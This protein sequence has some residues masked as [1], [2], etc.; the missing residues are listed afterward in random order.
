MKINDSNLN[1]TDDIKNCINNDNINKI[2]ET[3]DNQ[4]MI[5]NK[6]TLIKK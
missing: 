3:K 5:F 4:S 6:S 1:E 2:N